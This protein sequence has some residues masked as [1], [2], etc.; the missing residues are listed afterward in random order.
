LNVAKSERKR[1][2]G[3][4]RA[5]GNQDKMTSPFILTNPPS[6]SAQRRVGVGGSTAVE[7]VT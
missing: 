4:Y 2:N 3:F 6:L 5:T 1:M 7:Q